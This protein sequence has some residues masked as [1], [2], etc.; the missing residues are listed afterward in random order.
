MTDR[1]WSEVL[2]D[3]S[4]NKFNNTVFRD[5]YNTGAAVDISGDIVIRGAVQTDRINNNNFIDI[6]IS[7]I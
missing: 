7:G 1:T 6:I 5:Y 3:P 2:S 4:S